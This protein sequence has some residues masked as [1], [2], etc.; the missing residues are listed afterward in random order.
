MLDRRFLLA[1]ALLWAAVVPAAAFEKRPFD[2]KAFDTAKAGGKSI[3][4]DITAP[5]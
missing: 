4:I 3:L 1:T 2:A 5:W